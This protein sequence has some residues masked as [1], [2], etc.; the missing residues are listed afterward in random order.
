M[1]AAERAWCDTISVLGNQA[2]RD[3]TFELACRAIDEGIPGDFAEC[4]VMSG[5]HPAIMAKAS[6]VRGVTRIVHL[7]DSFDKFPQPGPDDVEVYKRD[8]G[9]NA[10][11]LHGKPMNVI[12]GTL[13]QVR[14]NMEK[15]RIP[16]TMLRYHKGWIQ[17]TLVAEQPPT[18]ALLRV[19]V[20]LYDS[21]VPVYKY[22]YPLMPSGAFIISDDWGTSDVAP[23][24]I[25]TVKT[26]GYTPTVTPVVGQETSVWWRKP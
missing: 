24:R 12:T 6:L 19:D 2:N 5:G 8:Y 7:Y 4:G 14:S 21:T 10:D 23:A 17:E 18:L 13:T 9:V 26:L 1:N 3:L 16:D 20:D 22:L 25:A 11:R 15:W